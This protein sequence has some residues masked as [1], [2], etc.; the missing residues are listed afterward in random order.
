[1]MIKLSTKGSTITMEQ[2]N[3]GSKVKITVRNECVGGGGRASVETIWTDK[4][5]ANIFYKKRLM[6]GYRKEL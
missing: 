2:K 3:K 4:D 6:D 5:Q 1:M